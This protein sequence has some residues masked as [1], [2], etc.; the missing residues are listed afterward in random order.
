[1]ASFYPQLGHSNS[2]CR[3]M[4]LQ[5]PRYGDDK[6]KDWYS[7]TNLLD[8]CWQCTSCHEPK[9]SPTDCKAG[10]TTHAPTSSATP[11]SADT[12]HKRP[13]QNIVASLADTGRTPHPR[14][15]DRKAAPSKAETSPSALNHLPTQ[16]S[17]EEREALYAQ[18]I[19]QYL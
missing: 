2:G 7:Y 18:M 8:K 12:G 14:A 6:N 4:T 10:R 11:S 13:P 15:G 5:R 19:Q 16:P 9:T 17:K 3:I 1:M